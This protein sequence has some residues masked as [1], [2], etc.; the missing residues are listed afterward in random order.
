MTDEPAETPQQVQERGRLVDHFKRA[1]QI[2][3]G[4]SITVACTNLFPGTF[5]SFPPDSSFWLFC[6]FFVTAV[7]IFHGGDRS[8]DIKYLHRRPAGFW[9]HAAYVWDVYMLLITALFFVKIAQSVPIPHGA[10]P[11][12]MNPNAQTSPHNFY[13]WM[14]AMLVFDVGVLIVDGI[15]SHLLAVGGAKL[16]AYVTWTVMNLAL[17]LACLGAALCPPSSVSEGTIAIGVFVLAFIRT[18]LDYVLGYRFL[19]P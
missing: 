14:G 8:L 1:Y 6:A 16:G 3:V 10:L 12:S 13:L 7:P 11:S 19:F 2:I 5:L 4:L 9:G 15:K 18:F 17:G